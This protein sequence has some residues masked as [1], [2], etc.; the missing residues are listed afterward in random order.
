MVESVSLFLGI[1]GAEDLEKK[2]E[3]IIEK[4]KHH[5][6]WLASAKQ[7]VKSLLF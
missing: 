7:E 5:K 6:D 1:L 4:K 3:N 2:N